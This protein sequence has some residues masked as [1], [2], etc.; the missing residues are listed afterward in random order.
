MRCHVGRHTDGD[1]LRTVDDEV[2]EA[3]RKDFRLNFGTIVVAD[4]VDGVAIDVANHFEGK[5]VHSRLG[6]THSRGFIAVDGTKV[7]MAIDEW[8]SKGEWLG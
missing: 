2:R 1:T 4:E 8:I 6:V 3:G 5:A 7:T